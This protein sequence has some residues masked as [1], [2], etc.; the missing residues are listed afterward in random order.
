MRTE[1]HT[2]RLMKNM[3]TAPTIG[4]SP[5]R[6]S[7]ITRI[8]PWSWRHGRGRRV[9]ENRGFGG[10]QKARLSST[11]LHSFDSGFAEVSLHL[12]VDLHVTHEAEGREKRT[13]TAPSQKQRYGDGFQIQQLKNE[14]SPDVKIQQ[15][16]SLVVLR[17]CLNPNNFH[18]LKQE[19]H[20]WMRQR[21]T[22][23]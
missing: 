15:D 11:H 7:R 1:G 6:G 16:L 14:T 3:V 12:H 20:N 22:P 4:T 5:I 9:G 21:A 18:G 19:E 17:V 2:G 10:F 8:I 13:V 23:C